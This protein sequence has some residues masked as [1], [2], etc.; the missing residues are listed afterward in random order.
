VLP[1]SAGDGVVAGVA[2]FRF[3][4]VHA[5]CEGLIWSAATASAETLDWRDGVDQRD[6]LF[7]VMHVRAGLNQRQ[8]VPSAT[9][10]TWR[11]ELFFVRSVVLE[12]VFPQTNRSH[13]APSTTVLSDAAFVEA[14]IDSRISAAKTPTTLRGRG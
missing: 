7:G 8:G 13:R 6:R 14:G 3:G 11:L 12:T 5:I 4:V 1:Q 10:A 2:N 9:H